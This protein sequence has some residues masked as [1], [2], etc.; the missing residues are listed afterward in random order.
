MSSDDEFI[1]DELIKLNSSP[2]LQKHIASFE[3]YEHEWKIQWSY[4]KFYGI[5]CIKCNYSV[6]CRFDGEGQ[7]K[8][9][10]Y[11]DLDEKCSF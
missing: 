11:N 4:L 3:P 7:Y 9:M 10:K 5:E 1:N 6:Y 8:Y 2:I